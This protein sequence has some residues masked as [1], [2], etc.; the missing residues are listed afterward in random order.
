M[1]ILMNQ[2][3]LL[4]EGIKHNGGEKMGWFKREKQGITT[5]SSEK[6]ETPE[7]LWYQCPKCKTVASS[8]RPQSKSM[9]LWK[10]RTS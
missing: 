2:L 1:F 9:G 8:E 7:G 6:K 10:L 5:S 3:L 4:V